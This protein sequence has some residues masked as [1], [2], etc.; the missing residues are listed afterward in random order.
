MRARGGVVDDQSDNRQDGTIKGATWTQPGA[1][2]GED[3]RT[4]ASE[5]PPDPSEVD[6]DGF[7]LTFSNAFLTYEPGSGDPQG[8]L[9]N[10]VIDYGSEWETVQMKDFL[11]QM[12]KPHWDNM[13]WEV[14]T[15]HREVYQVKTAP[16][17][18]PRKR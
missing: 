2:L 14:N 5:S 9:G 10:L 11:Y 16:S 17:G 8:A 18:A 7:L 12:R 4:T 15:S 6:A 3:G 13:F 1:P